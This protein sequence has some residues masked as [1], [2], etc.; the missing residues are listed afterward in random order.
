LPDKDNARDKDG[1]YYGGKI[2]ANQAYVKKSRSIG[3]EIIK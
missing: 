2:C 1:Y 3:K